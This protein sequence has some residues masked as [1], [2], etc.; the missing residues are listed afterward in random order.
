M[1]FWKTFDIE[2]IKFRE[3]QHEIDFEIGDSFFQHFEDNEILEK[4]NLTTRVIMDKGVN[5]IEL[6]FHIQ[7]TVQL[8]CDR[9]LEVFDH[10]LDITEKMIYKYG[11]EEQE[12]DENVYMITRDTPSIN[13]AQLIYEYILL[14]LPAKKIHPDYRNELDDEDFDGEGGFVY[15]D[16]DQEEFEEEEDVK[17]EE[18]TPKPIDPRWEQLLKLKN[19]EQS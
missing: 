8:T 7:G 9:S 18:E 10:P 3:G 1:K 11:S 2:V 6:T 4:G 19:K 17:E 13:V 5:V 16:E 15:F 14:A 12:I